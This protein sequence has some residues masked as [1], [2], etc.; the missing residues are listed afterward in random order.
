M[1]GILADEISVLTE[2]Y[3]KILQEKNEHISFLFITDGNAVSQYCEAVFTEILKK[4]LNVKVFFLSVISPALDNPVFGKREGIQFLRSLDEMTWN[5][6][7]IT[8]LLLDLKKIA[9]EIPETRSKVLSFLKKVIAKQ[10]LNEQN[11]L[12]LSSI[13]PDL[14]AWS[15]PTT[16]LAELELSSVLSKCTSS[17]IVSF[18]SN[19][20]NEITNAKLNTRWFSLRTDHVFGP[21]I[22]DTS[23]IKFSCVTSV[24]PG[25]N[26][27]IQAADN[28]EFFSCTYI[29]DILLCCLKCYFIEENSA[30]Y[31]V[32]SYDINRTDIP[33]SVYKMFPAAVLNIEITRN[34]V[35]KPKYHNLENLKL[36]ST[37]WKA[38]ISKDEAIYRTICTK[39]GVEYASSRVNAVYHGRL[40]ALQNLELEILKEIDAICKTNGIKYFLVGGSLLGAVRHQGFIPWDDDLDI[41]MLREDF[42][43]FRVVCPQNLSSKY[44]YQSYRIDSQSHYIFDKIRVKNT[45]FATAFS[46][47]FPIDNGAFVDILVYDK[48]SK[49]V[50]IQKIHI[51]LI[52]ILKHVINIR[53]NNKPRNGSHYMASVILLPF[54]RLIPF[55]VYHYIYEKLIRLFNRS[56][57]NYYIDSVGMNLMKGAFQKECIIGEP[58][59]VP[60]ETTQAPIPPGWNEYLIHWYGDNYMEVP[61]ISSRNSGHKLA[62]IDLGDAKENI[63]CEEDKHTG[64]TER[65]SL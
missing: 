57:S 65:T 60:F 41:G 8:T 1:D 64:T 35:G 26:Q 6:P 23:V 16:H 49:H 36:R 61:V 52:N 9:Y 30:V 14:P 51:R 47:K 21:H 39:C 25:S 55:R 40:K 46:R 53:W 48:T 7:V 29:R 63:N 27:K 24:L 37:G 43:K 45:F 32:A 11:R 12:I 22:E 44:T 42:E 20:E 15:G 31:N 33:I 19:L 2:E 34:G 17:D 62:Q 58:Q 38:A 4:D 59:Y 18:L 3:Q 56:N 28:N 13:L 10:N 50:R 5:T 54:M